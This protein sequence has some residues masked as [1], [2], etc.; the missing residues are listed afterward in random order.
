[1]RILASQR[2][3]RTSGDDQGEIVLSAL[4]DP[5]Y[6]SS[7]SLSFTSFK[8]SKSSTQQGHYEYSW[9]LAPSSMFL[10]L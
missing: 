3:F 7:L 10:E 1:M 5:P 4:P 6:I 9:A 2:R 8:F